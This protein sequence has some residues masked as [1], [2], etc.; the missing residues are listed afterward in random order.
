MA[1]SNIKLKKIGRELREWI[2]LGC[3]AGMRKSAN[4]YERLKATEPVL[5][6]QYIKR[7]IDL[8]GRS[9]A[10]IQHAV[11]TYGAQVFTESLTLCGSETKTEIDNELSSIE[12]YAQGLYDRRQLGESWDDLA[13][14]ILTN[15]T[16]EVTPWIFPIPQDYTDIWG[17]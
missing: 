8:P 15:I 5:A 14:D 2:F 4:E 6:E 17:E 10:R 11:D 1:I 7:A 9:R 16:D 3:R 12:E 13:S